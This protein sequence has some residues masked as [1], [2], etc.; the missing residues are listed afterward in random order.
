ML[1]YIAKISIPLLAATLLFGGCGKTEPLRGS[2]MVSD[3]ST[4]AGS[5][6]TPDEPN[7]TL[8]A[9]RRAEFLNRIRTADPQKATIE[10]AVINEK[11]ELGIIV[12][13]QTQLDEVPKLLKAMLVQMNQA[14]PGQD[15]NAI[16]YTPTNPPRTLGTAHL[17]VRTRD[18]TYQPVSAP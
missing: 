1:T 13:R 6:L 15:L 11:N 10:R 8:L 18:M 9:R 5:P 3:R 16:A 4:P 12:S 17:D 7:S 14:F 2:S